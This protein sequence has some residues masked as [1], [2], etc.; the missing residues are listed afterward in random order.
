MTVFFA[1]PNN[2]E[3]VN[4]CGVKLLEKRSVEAIENNME[5]IENNI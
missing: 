3:A 5:A 1:H 2:Y 4:N